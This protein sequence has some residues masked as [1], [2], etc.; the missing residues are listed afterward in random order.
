MQNNNEA[1]DV[2]TSVLKLKTS[3]L[4]WHKENCSSLPE[5]IYQVPK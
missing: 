1:K 4:K 3:P 5:L 2:T